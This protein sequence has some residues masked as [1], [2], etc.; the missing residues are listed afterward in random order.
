M[1]AAINDSIRKW[2]EFTVKDW[3]ASIAKA[4]IGWSNDLVNSFKSSLK[5]SG[6]GDIET[7]YFNF[8]FYGKFPDIGVGRG[9]PLAKRSSKKTKRKRK[10]W[11]NKPFYANLNAIT[12]I[13]AKQ[14]GSIAAANMVHSIE[15]KIVING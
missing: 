3:K 12:N 11:L 2:Q 14:Y 7:I 6:N 9:L 1:D 5:E 13:M 15:N 4:R 8:L 10:K